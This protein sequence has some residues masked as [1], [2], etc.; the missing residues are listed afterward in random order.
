MVFSTEPPFMNPYRQ[1]NN[2][3]EAEDSVIH[4][5]LMTWGRRLKRV[6]VTI[7]LTNGVKNTFT[8]YRGDSLVDFAKKLLEEAKKH[9]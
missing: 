7:T 2:I 6:D 4:I 5:I 8:H 1:V 9:L 3:C